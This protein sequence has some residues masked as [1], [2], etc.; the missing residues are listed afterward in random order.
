LG[1]GVEIYRL[2]EGTRNRRPIRN[3]T[4][5]PNWQNG[6]KPKNLGSKD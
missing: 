4:I 5:K 6:K 2:A 3:T 1:E